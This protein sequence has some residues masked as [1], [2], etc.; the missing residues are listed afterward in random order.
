VLVSQRV[1]ELAAPDG[2]TFAEAGEARLKGF[3]H[4]VRVLEASRA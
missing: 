4:A 2:V 1:A 3:A